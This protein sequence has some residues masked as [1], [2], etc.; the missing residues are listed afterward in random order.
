MSDKLPSIDDFAEDNSNLPSA[1]DII[2]EE[3]LPSVEDFIEKEEEDI[4]EEKIEE[5]VEEAEDLTEVIRLINDVRK[6]IPNIPEIKY[7]DEELRVLSEQL[8]EVRESIP[9]V[10]EVKYYDAEVELSLIHI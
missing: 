4:V 10:P 8:I 5:P 9:T 3:N 7:Y 2:K 1:E 6:D